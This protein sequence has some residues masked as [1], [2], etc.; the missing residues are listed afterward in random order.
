MNILVV[1]GISQQESREEALRI[2]RDTHTPGIG[3]TAAMLEGHIEHGWAALSHRHDRG[4][5]SDP[6]VDGIQEARR[7]SRSWRHRGHWRQTAQVE[8]PPLS[9]QTVSPS[10]SRFRKRSHLKTPR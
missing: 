8:G 6:T 3:G 9:R 10:P 5:E 7:H 2:G 1:S 4:A